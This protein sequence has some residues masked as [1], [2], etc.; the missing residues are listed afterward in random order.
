MPEYKCKKC[1]TKFEAAAVSCGDKEAVKCPACGSE[2]IEEIKPSD[3]NEMLRS[4]FARRR[5]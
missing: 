1:Q 3:V 2:K 5:G 4:F